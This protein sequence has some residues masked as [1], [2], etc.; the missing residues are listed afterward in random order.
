MF[1]FNGLIQSCGWPCCAAIFANWF[2]KRGRGITIGLWQSSANF[3]NV[4]GALLTSFLTATVGLG[5]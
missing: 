4:G 3:G 1:A 5:W 2:G